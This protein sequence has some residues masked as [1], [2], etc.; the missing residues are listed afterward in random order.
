MSIS[1]VRPSPLHHPVNRGWVCPA[2]QRESLYNKSPPIG[3]TWLN[4][5]HIVNRGRHSDLEELVIALAVSLPMSINQST[6][7][8]TA[9]NQLHSN[10]YKDE[11]TIQQWVNP[12]E[13]QFR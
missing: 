12:K 11:F 6:L 9:V 13:H 7:L 2:A 10:A 8:F 5:R 1:K 3:A 4:T